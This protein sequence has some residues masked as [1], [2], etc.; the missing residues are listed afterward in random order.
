MLSA[1]TM[2]AI[3]AIGIARTATTIITSSINAPQT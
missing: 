1:T 2:L 3:A